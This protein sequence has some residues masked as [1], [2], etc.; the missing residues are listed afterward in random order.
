MLSATDILLAYPRAAE[1][2]DGCIYLD[3]LRLWLDTYTGAP[4][5]WV[6]TYLDGSQELI[7]TLTDIEHALSRS[8]APGATTT[9]LDA[10]KL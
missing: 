9:W 7:D 6:C 8:T 10:G 2:E 3:H 4:E 1:G 5:G